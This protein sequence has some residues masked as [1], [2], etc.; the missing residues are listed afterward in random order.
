M[1]ASRGDSQG[2]AGVVILLF[3]VLSLATLHS[4]CAGVTAQSNPGG[5]TASITSPTSGATVSAS[6]TVSAN[7]SANIVGVQFKLD[8]AN[9]GAEKTS[10]PFSISWDTTA[11]ANGQH[12]LTAVARNAA[13]QTGNSAPVSITVQNSSGGGPSISITSP[14]SG[15]TLSGT[16]TVTAVASSTIGIAG[17]QFLL[18]GANLGAEVT[19][20]PYSYPWDTTAS[21]NGTHT[22]TARARDTAGT[23]ATSIG[24]TATVS[25]GGSGGSSFQARCSASG[26]VRCIGFDVPADIAGVYGDNKG[27]TPGAPGNDPVIDTAVFASGGGSLKF[28]IPSQSGEGDSGA[29]FTNFSTDLN[30]QFAA[31]NADPN[32]CEF[33]IQWRQRFSGPGGLLDTIYTSTTGGNANG[34]K[35]VIIS[36]G[37]RIGFLANSCVDIDVPVQDTEQLGYPQM[38]HSCGTKMSDPGPP[39]TTSYDGLYEPIGSPPTDF[40]RQNAIRTPGVGCT[41][42]NSAPCFKYFPNEWMTFQAHIKVASWFHNTLPYHHDSTIQLWVAREGQ[43]SVLVLDYSPKSSPDTCSNA[44]PNVDEPPCQTGYDLAQA[45]GPNPPN[46]TAAKFGKIWL[47][48]FHTHKNPTQVHPTAYTWY[49]ELIISRNKIADP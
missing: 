33:Y 26:V 19:A 32:N 41:S 3:L 25:N 2:S 23:T 37:D 14:T 44:W 11:A 21:S 22:L 1:R 28:T 30:T 8:G 9:L 4:G 48:P 10:P 34:W 36:E 45:V 7:A 15:A 18:D 12:T 42:N 43:P 46:T 27:I 38:Y 17:V 6:T 49:D 5:P 24:V 47:T 29:F 20:T 16:S 31:C 13:G 40:R 39:P 35:Q